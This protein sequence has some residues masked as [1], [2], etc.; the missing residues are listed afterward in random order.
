MGLGEI[1]LG[2]IG[3]G[4]SS[5]PFFSLHRPMSEVPDLEGRGGLDLPH[6]AGTGHGPGQL[7]GGL[8]HRHLPAR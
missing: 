8:L 2:C 7:G 5:P 3:D 1:S 4:F 6:P